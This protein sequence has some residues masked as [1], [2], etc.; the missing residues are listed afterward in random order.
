MDVRFKKALKL[1]TEQGLQYPQ[2]LLDIGCTQDSFMKLC[3]NCKCVGMDINGGENIVQADIN[4]RFPFD[5]KSFDIIF[6]GEIIEHSFDDSEFL[7]ECSRVLRDDGV[8][9][10]TTPNLVSLKNRFLMLLGREPRFAYQRYHYHVYTLKEIKKIVGEVFDIIMIQSSYILY[11][12]NREKHSG[13][14]F[15][16]L[17]DKFPQ[18]GEHFI[19]IV[20]KCG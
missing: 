7:R 12:S 16:W 11:S 13:R 5:D 14:F 4:E 18:F 17:A 19:M 15:E 8:M 20:K 9:I 10:L 3:P 6:A 1:M 2:D